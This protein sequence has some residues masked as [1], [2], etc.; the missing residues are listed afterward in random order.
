MKKSSY[1]AITFLICTLS[2]SAFAFDWTFGLGEKP[3]SSPIH[4]NYIRTETDKRDIQ[5]D[6]VKNQ[7]SEVR[8]LVNSLK[9]L[10][11]TDKV[12]VGNTINL[13]VND[14]DKI[15]KSYHNVCNGDNQSFYESY[16]YFFDQY[17]GAAMR[18]EDSVTYAIN[19]VQ[20]NN[21]SIIKNSKCNSERNCNKAKSDFFMQ[22]FNEKLAD[23]IEI[24][25][26]NK[27]LMSSLVEHFSN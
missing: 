2:S 14:L 25:N 5:I 12:I 23:N 17:L 16:T 18:I 20:I 9:Y 22:K 10:N 26:N 24:L 4:N 6:Y 11:D 19:Q 21:K 3:L 27:R 15:S 13:A 7:G 8:Y 1:I